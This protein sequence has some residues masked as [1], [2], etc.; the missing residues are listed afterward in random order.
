MDYD[1]QSDGNISALLKYEREQEREQNRFDNFIEA[2]IAG[3]VI[4]KY[5]ESRAMFQRL[6]ERYD[7]EHYSY[8]DFIS[9]QV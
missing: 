4:V 6:S 8:E 9:E 7:F 5:E 3:D 1:R 2:C